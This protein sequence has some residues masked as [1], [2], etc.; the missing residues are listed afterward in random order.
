MDT[1]TTLLRG[2][3]YPGRG[4]ITG[5]SPGG[6]AVFAYF[7]MGRSENSRNRVFRQEGKSLCIDLQDPSKVQ[8]PSLICYTPVR[9]L[10]GQ[11][12]VTNGDQ[13]DTLCEVLSAGGSF[14]KA[15]DTR[16]YEPDCPNYTPRISALLGGDGY[17]MSILKRAP[18]DGACLRLY[19]SYP[20]QPGCG[21][22]I[23]TYLHDGNPLPAFTGTPKPVSLP[24]DPEELTALLWDALDA[25]NRVSLNVRYTNLSTG[26]FHTCLRNRHTGDEPC[27]N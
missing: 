19:W 14:R 27:R 21:H 10:D 8:D 16:C 3:S 24:E 4:I 13:T 12:I 1:V 9:V 7:I 22:L 18:L 5:F 2:N 20:P 25:E 17:Q 26:Q 6:R 23:H 15:L 11:I